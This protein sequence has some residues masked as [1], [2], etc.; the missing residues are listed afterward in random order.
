MVD[1]KLRRCLETQKEYMFKVS[2]SPPYCNTLLT[3]DIVA[4]QRLDGP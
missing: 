2:V 4:L 1:T 3:L